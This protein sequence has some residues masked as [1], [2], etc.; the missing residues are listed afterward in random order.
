MSAEQPLVNISSAK[1]L[2]FYL[3]FALLLSKS[4]HHARESVGRLKSPQLSAALTAP[5]LR[6]LHRAEDIGSVLKGGVKVC[7]RRLVNELLGSLVTEFVRNFGREGATP[8]QRGSNASLF[9]RVQAVKL[10]RHN[11]LRHLKAT[12]QPRWSPTWWVT[13]TAH[14]GSPSIEAGAIARTQQAS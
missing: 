5:R 7:Q 13:M 12:P 6:T 2:L 3:E 8:I 14:M 4:P 9:G 1:E 11:A 10:I